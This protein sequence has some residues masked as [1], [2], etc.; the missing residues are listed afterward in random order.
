MYTSLDGR[1]ACE[2][3]RYFAA[4]LL[5]SPCLTVVKQVAKSSPNNYRFF[6]S[7][8]EVEDDT[9]ELWRRYSYV[10]AASL[11]YRQRRDNSVPQSIR[12]PSRVASQ[13]RT[14][15]MK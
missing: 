1:A 6:S 5:S 11:L 15:D 8:S 2:V 12:A 9:F 7:K 14:R 4:S 13:P 10:A 3:L